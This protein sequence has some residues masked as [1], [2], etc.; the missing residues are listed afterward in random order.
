M[1]G[2][3]RLYFNQ[4]NISYDNNNNNNNNNNNFNNNIERMFLFQEQTL[5]GGAI[6]SISSSS[7]PSSITTSPSTTTTSSP[8]TTSTLISNNNNNN[9]STSTTNNNNSNIGWNQN[10]ISNIP[11]LSQQQ[12]Q[13]FPPPQQLPPAVAQPKQVHHSH[14]QQK[15][16]HQYPPAN[17]PITHIPPSPQ[18][19]SIFPTPY[20]Y[21]SSNIEQNTTWIHSFDQHVRQDQHHQPNIAYI[22]PNYPVNINSDASIPCHPY[23]YPVSSSSY[24]ISPL[25]QGTEV[26]QFSGM[27]STGVRGVI[28]TPNRNQLYYYPQYN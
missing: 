25:Q 26:N 14:Q 13:I 17:V 16:S 24:L 9:N 15:L 12:P 28:S 7:L 18:V 6:S 21:T 3:K 5:P 20:E 27:T 22:Y 8:T 10:N 19:P 1:D 23:Q 11:Y 2:R 4:K